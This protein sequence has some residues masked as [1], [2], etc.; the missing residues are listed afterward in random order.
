MVADIDAS[1]FQSITE[2]TGTLDGNFYKITNL[3]KP[4]F[5]TVKNDGIVKNI[6]FE[7]VNISSGDNDGDAGAVCCKA[8]GASRI[9]NCGILPTTVNRDQDGNITG[10]SGS[11]VTGSAN[12]GGIVGLLDGTSRVI[13]CYSYAN[14]S[15]GP[16]KGWHRRK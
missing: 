7:G 3:E 13:N 5:T 11:S 2:F 12:V 9:Y 14:A 6:T 4:L 15:G 16:K 10:F 1:G 8:E